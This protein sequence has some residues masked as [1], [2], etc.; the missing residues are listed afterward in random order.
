MPLL[1]T[2]IHILKQKIKTPRCGGEQLVD[3]ELHSEAQAAELC[4]PSYYPHQLLLHTSEGARESWAPEPGGE[5]AETNLFPSA[6]FHGSQRPRICALLAQRHTVENLQCTSWLGPEIMSPCP[7]T[8]GPLYWRCNMSL[9]RPLMRRQ[10]RVTGV[11]RSRERSQSRA[12]TS[13][14]HHQHVCPFTSLVLLVRPPHTSLDEKDRYRSFALCLSLWILGP[15]CGGLL[16]EPHSQPKHW[17]NP[18]TWLLIDK[19]E[20]H[21]PASCIPGQDL[22]L[23]LLF[24]FDFF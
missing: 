9:Q 7:C 22:L 4:P 12:P 10:Q 16:S 8:A 21:Q 1:N 11:V 23:F 5:A 19:E 15:T 3:S 24:L 2:Y 20:L 13:Q 17:S 6:A 18:P 14:L